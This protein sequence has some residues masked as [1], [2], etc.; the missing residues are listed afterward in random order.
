MCARSN[1]LQYYVSRT[2][3]WKTYEEASMTENF[4]LKTT[5]TTEFLPIFVVVVFT[6]R[7]NIDMAGNGGSRANEFTSVK[8]RNAFCCVMHLSQS[9]CVSFFSLSVWRCVLLFAITTSSRRGNYRFGISLSQ[10]HAWRQTYV[11]RPAGR[12]S[13]HIFL[14]PAVPYSFWTKS[15]TMEAKLPALFRHS[16]QGPRNSRLSSLG[17][18]VAF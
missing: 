8:K 15:I 14:D 5:E 11:D 13:A 18:G 7:T 9:L 16:Y 17:G 6:C 3:L 1:L 10:S 4:T 12:F 2:V